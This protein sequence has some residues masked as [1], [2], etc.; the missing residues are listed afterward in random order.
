[1]PVPLGDDFLR[2]SLYHG[3]YS[4]DDVEDSLFAITP[5][6]TFRA[7]DQL[8]HIRGEEPDNEHNLAFFSEEE[9][10]SHNPTAACHSMR[11][12]CGWRAGPDTPLPKQGAMRHSPR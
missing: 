8:I 1:M 11:E 7:A 12:K 2:T 9:S 10:S 5:K 3:H 6:R 4:G